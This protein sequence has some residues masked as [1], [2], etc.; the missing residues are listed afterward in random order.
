MKHRKSALAGL[1][2]EQH[3]K[4]VERLVDEGWSASKTN[5]GHVK[6]THPNA[7]QPVFTSSTPSCPHAAVKLRQQASRTLHQAT[8]PVPP[9]VDLSLSRTERK[10]GCPGQDV[11]LRKERKKRWSPVKHVRRE[12]EIAI[13]IEQPPQPIPEDHEGQDAVPAVAAEVRRTTDPMQ[14][15]HAFKTPARAPAADPVAMFLHVEASRGAALPAPLVLETVNRDMLELAMRLLKGEMQPIAVTQDMVGKVLW[16]PGSGDVVMTSAGLDLRGGLPDS[17]RLDAMPPSP[18]PAP[19]SAPHTASILDAP[20][21]PVTELRAPGV[22]DGGDHDLN[23]F[24][25]ATLAILRAESTPMSVQDVAGILA[26]INGVEN[27]ASHIETVRHRLRWLAK[28]GYA[29]VSRFDTRRTLYA[30]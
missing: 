26:K 19:A 12:N 6:L 24:R 25:G 28:N 1:T 17:A 21:A 2:D 11:K 8:L 13:A 4:Q 18:A 10:I 9:P 27:T 14:N 29:T 16:V 23:P 20:A 3:R 15:V 5:G 30:A 7:N 22:A